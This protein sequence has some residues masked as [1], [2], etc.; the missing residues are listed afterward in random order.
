[1]LNHRDLEYVRL[2]F[3]DRAAAGQ[4]LAKAL[5][6]HHCGPD[7]IVLAL[8]RGGV[9][10]AFPVAA[11]LHAELDVIVVRKLG[12][13]GH[14]EL[15]MGA[16]AAGGVR[17]LN[18][19]VI[20]GARI[21]PADLEAVAARESVELERRNRRYRGA[22]PPP[23]VEARG[24]V[25]VDDGLATGATMNAAVSAIRAK[26]PARITIAVPV[27]PP[28]TAAEFG[29]KV[30]RVVCL[31]T[32]DPFMGVGCWYEDFAQTTDEAVRALLA[33]FRSSRRPG[34]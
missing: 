34:A 10:V 31:A 24:V 2:P 15:A 22:R 13:P 4:L 23:T 20:R 27:A 19:E 17:V 14:E 6:G 5:E 12:V 26:R 7:V 30:E 28:D 8:P 29:H 1:M 25:L 33:E 9:P 16:I 18:Q 32:P 21:L 11:A 3:S